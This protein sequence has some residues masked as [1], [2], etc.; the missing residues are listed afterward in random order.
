[1]IERFLAKGIAI[2]GVD[3]GESFGS[4]AGR[5]IYSALHQHLVTTFHFDARACLLARSRGG[6][7]LY[8]WAADHPDKICCIAGI[9]PVC[10]LRSYPGLNRTSRACEMTV[11]ELREALPKH[12]P[13]DRLAPLAKANVPIFHIHGNVDAVV[14][15][16]ANS[17]T[18]AN[19]YRQLGGSMQL[20]IA[21]NQGH[22]MWR[23][24]FECQPLIEFVI[25]HALA[26]TDVIPHTFEP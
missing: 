8:N 23:G 17:E 26:K 6:L 5:S 12:N 3:V 21:P 10:D 1:M 22:N 4:P 25:T 2:A 18:V 13:I 16:E 19:T 20:E 15:L 11:D 24:F 9:Y 7:M 14:P